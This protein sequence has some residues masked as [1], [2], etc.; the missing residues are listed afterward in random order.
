[1]GIFGTSKPRVT[2]SELKRA[3]NDMVAAGLNRE[4]RAEVIAALQSHMDSD[5]NSHKG[6]DEREITAT[7]N[8]M[9]EMDDRHQNVPTEK[10]EKVRK[11]FTKYLKF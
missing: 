9:E 4:E 6:L 5:L 1:M 8:A 3:R 11:I 2:E 10:I 7:L